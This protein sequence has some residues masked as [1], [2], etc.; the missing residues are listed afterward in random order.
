MRL[1]RGTG[2]ILYELY[3]R[4]RKIGRLC[5]AP[6]GAVVLRLD[7]FPT[8]ADAAFA[9]SLAHAG[10]LAYQA[11]R[12][13]AGSPASAA[14]STR[15]A[16]GGAAGTTSPAAR[17]DS[18]AIDLRPGDIEISQPGPVDEPGRESWSARIPLAGPGTPEVFLLAAAR[19]MWEAVRRAGYAGRP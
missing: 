17:P 16:A 19:R 5:T 11:E 6:D 2:P 7:G 1:R 4:D 12:A 14:V 10:L 8:P 18:E 15:W 9:A 13:P 3:D